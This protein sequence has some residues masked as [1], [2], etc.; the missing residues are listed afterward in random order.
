MTAGVIVPL[1]WA[2]YVS[3]PASH[4]PAV[5]TAKVVAEPRKPAPTPTEDL[6][7]SIPPSP[8]ATPA[9]PKTAQVAPPSKPSAPPPAL[10]QPPLEPATKATRA[11]TTTVFAAQRAKDRALPAVVDSYNGA[12]IITI[13]AAL[14]ENEQLRAGCP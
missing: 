12:H 3:R 1:V 11:H 6:T 4:T 8:G 5:K 7:A 10:A 9:P 2:A 14:S 13:C